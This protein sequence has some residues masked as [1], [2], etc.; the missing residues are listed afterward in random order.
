MLQERDNHFFKYTFIVYNY[1]YM[2][3]KR[4]RK[5]KLRKVIAKTFTL[6]TVEGTI[7]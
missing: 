1:T 5:T 4:E 3:D 6:H 2:E 7:K